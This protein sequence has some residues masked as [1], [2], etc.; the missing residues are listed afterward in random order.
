MK[1]VLE[2]AGAGLNEVVKV[3][4]S[5]KTMG[6]FSDVNKVYPKY[7]GGSKPARSTVE[8]SALPRG[9][10]AEMEAVARVP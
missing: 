2:A 8:V 3:T 1:A 6:G 5:L 4:L 10:L 9:A 7:F